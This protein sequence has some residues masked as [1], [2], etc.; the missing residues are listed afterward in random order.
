LFHPDIFHIHIVCAAESEI[1]HFIDLT[2]IE[3]MLKLCT[4]INLFDTIFENN[5]H[6]SK[7]IFNNYHQSE[8][9]KLPTKGN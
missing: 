1:K 3:T 8:I 9:I 6:L 2:Q 5:H 7:L 4:E